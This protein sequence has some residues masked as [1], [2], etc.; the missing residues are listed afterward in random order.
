MTLRASSLLLPIF[1]DAVFIGTVPPP[2][3][4]LNRQDY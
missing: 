1:A 2:V 3:G 4:E